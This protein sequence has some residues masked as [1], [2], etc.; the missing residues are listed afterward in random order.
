MSEIGCDRTALENI[1]LWSYFTEMPRTLTYLAQDV[2]RVVGNTLGRQP[3][4]SDCVRPLTT[5]ITRL[6]SFRIVMRKQQNLDP[7]LY[8]AFA[9]YVARCVLTHH[10]ASIERG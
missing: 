2:Y 4:K 10:W 3:R 8:R 5:A 7:A 9:G 1:R 6:S